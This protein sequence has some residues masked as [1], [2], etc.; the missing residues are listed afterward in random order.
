MMG[1]YE[2]WCWYVQQHM[3]DIKA[4]IVLVNMLFLTTAGGSEI[5][6]GK[7]MRKG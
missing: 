7:S 3:G 4:F 1:I 2:G 5:K 6:K